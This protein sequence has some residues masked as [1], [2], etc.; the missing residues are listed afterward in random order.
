MLQTST[1]MNIQIKTTTDMKQTN[2][3]WYSTSN[4]KKLLLASLAA[5]LGI[6]VFLIIKF[7]LIEWVYIA[8][9]LL[10]I[11]GMVV[12][13]LLFRATP[14]QE[15]TEQSNAVSELK[16]ELEQQQQEAVPNT[17]DGKYT[18][19]F[20]LMQTINRWM[21]AL[22]ESDQEY[23]NA[24]RAE[25]SRVLASYGYMFLELTPDSLYC[26]DYER[27]PIDKLDK[28]KIA[29]TAIVTR[30]SRSIVI[31]GKAFIPDNYGEQ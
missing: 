18:D 25:I 28:P 22:P 21:D 24:T 9:S 15:G 6:L 3:K 4:G 10:A 17:L 8:I 11:T 31:K 27:V 13:N 14:K 16:A 5:I 23:V 7:T 29:G 26:Y 12:Y 2:H 1:N 20:I 19:C 30:R